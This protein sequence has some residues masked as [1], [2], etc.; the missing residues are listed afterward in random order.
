[1]KKLE[2][3]TQ[4]D[5]SHWGLS[6]WY[7]ENE[8]ALAAALAEGVSFDTGWYSSKKEIASARIYS[9]EGKIMVEVS[10][11]DDFDTQG[12]ASVTA[13]EAT[14]AAVADAVDQAMEDAEADRNDNQT[15][16]GFCILHHQ[17]MHPEGMPLVLWVE[18]YLV[19]TGWGEDLS[20]SGDNY[21]W[22]GWQHDGADDS[23]GIPHPDIPLELVTAFEKFAHD[24]AFGRINASSMR[25]G[26][27]EI[28]AWRKELP[29]R[30]DP[31]DY[32][33]MGWV[34]SDGRP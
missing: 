16:E 5:G 21:H 25:T 17:T 19:N 26:D 10:V 18:T 12:S 1:M 23:V 4:G 2:T 29:E 14:L 15:Y 24:W 22:W 31:S 8:E 20:P 27:W 34:G 9:I 33:G 6:D 28:R 32:V 11:S 7:P 30:E 13:S 3:F